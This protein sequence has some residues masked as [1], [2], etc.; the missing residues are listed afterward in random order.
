MQ[1]AIQKERKIGTCCEYPQH[2]IRARECKSRL[3]FLPVC[4]SPTSRPR[5]KVLVQFSFSPHSRSANHTVEPMFRQRYD[6]PSAAKRK[7]R[8]MPIV[9]PKF[10]RE[11]TCVMWRRAEQCT[12]TNTS[13]PKDSYASHAAHTR[14]THMFEPHSHD[15]IRRGASLCGLLDASQVRHSEHAAVA[16]QHSIQPTI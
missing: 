5:P 13:S 11:N 7:H 15:E 12:P 16:T 8:T 14:R 9:W 10:Y 2:N 1:L 6:G 4:C 3:V